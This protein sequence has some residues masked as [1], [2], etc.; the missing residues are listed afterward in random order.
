MSSV[1]PKPYD[2][3][4]PVEY[5]SIRLI[6]SD[7]NQ[8]EIKDLVSDIDVFEHLDKPYLTGVM[9]ILDNRDLFGAIDINGAT[10]INITLKTNLG[11]SGGNK[12]KEV[13]RE[14]F[15][16][17]IISSKKYQ[18]KG[19]MYTVHLLESF[20]YLSNMT[21]INKAY[22][23]TCSRIISKLI[24]NID[25]DNE[26]DFFS[27][28]KDIQ[29]MKVIIPYLSVTDA[30]AWIK[31]RAHTTEGYPFY[32]YTTLA[33]PRTINFFDLKTLLKANHINKIPYSFSST[34]THS[35][36]DDKIYSDRQ[37]TV[38]LD[39]KSNDTENLY[40]LIERG[41]LTSF[42]QHIDVTSQIKKDPITFEIEDVL[43]TLSNDQ[44]IDLSPS[45]FDYNINEIR[46]LTLPQITGKLITQIGGT[47]SYDTIESTGS[48]G[49]TRLNSYS[50]SIG[51]AGY[52]GQMVS[53]TM[54]ALMKKDPLTITVNGI[55]FLQGDESTTIGNKIRVSF[56][57]NDTEFP[58]TRTTDYKKSG[59]YLIYSARHSFRGN[60]Y[61]VSLT[62]MKLN[63]MDQNDT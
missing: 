7:D 61:T 52:K 47:F 3:S 63:G 34:K 31:N 38:I 19:E 35:E 51:T 4:Q 24:Q 29:N 54:D 50:E 28:E 45:S 5:K 60:A 48:R 27:T 57:I 8:I 25:T 16:D 58:S 62:G 33:G 32:L 44:I 6:I 43:D 59:D 9:N 15:I 11:S 21:S 42:V 17:H 30:M 41:M 2:H 26:I 40:T 53:R 20:E 46:R 1:N 18:E 10:R 49:D 37:R 22:V 13:T 23:G 12:N 55:D 39:Y 14:F 56:P 36:K